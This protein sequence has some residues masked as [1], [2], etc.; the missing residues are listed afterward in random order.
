MFDRIMENSMAI[1]ML[2]SLAFPIFL[3]G[4]LVKAVRHFRKPRWEPEAEPMSAP[5][6]ARAHNRIESEDWV[7]SH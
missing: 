4:T 1:W 7:P 2:V 3:V 5:A 6:G